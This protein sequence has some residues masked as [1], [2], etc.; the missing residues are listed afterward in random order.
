MAKVAVNTGGIGETSYRPDGLFYDEVNERDIIDLRNSSHKV[1]D[2]KRLLEREFNKAVAGE[3]RGE[4]GEWEIVNEPIVHSYVIQ[5]YSNT[6][7]FALYVDGTKFNE[8]EHIT[9]YF[10]NDS[11]EY[12]YGR[13]HVYERHTLYMKVNCVDNFRTDL[14]S[15]TTETAGRYMIGRASTRKKS[16]TILHCDIVGNPANYY[17]GQTYI[18]SGTVT[19]VIGDVVWAIT[20]TGGGTAGNFYE[21]KTVQA[22]IDLAAENY[23]STTNWT[24]LGTDWDGAGSWR[25]GVSGTSLVVGENGEDYTSGII[26]A[27]ASK[28]VV[29]NLI[30]LES[31]DNGA[32]WTTPTPALNTTDNTYYVNANNLY[33]LFYETHTNITK[34]AVN[35]EVLALGDVF[36]TST[37]KK[38]YGSHLMNSLINKVQDSSDWA[39]TTVPL[40]QTAFKEFPNNIL[41]T[42]NDSF[43]TTLANVITLNGATSPIATKA[44]PYITK[45][46]NKAYLNL[47]FKEMKFDVDWGD[48]SKFNI[49][50]NVSTTTDDN[51]N[52]VLIGQKRIELPYFIEDKE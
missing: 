13:G 6:G 43:A 33:M 23:A 36:A 21:A 26:Y 34:N 29:N 2:Y 31:T 47:V 8:G 35:S 25:T 32:T 40:I 3:V 15:G 30:S 41:S 18:D 5:N 45:E 9:F 14:I 11:G 48:D 51:A 17:R 42:W 22:S 49:V 50:D 27:K 20:A 46:N 7:V 19:T 4:E 16:N 12:A 44:L 28:K 52:T 39:G 24:D 37:F 10:I 38:E 1:Q